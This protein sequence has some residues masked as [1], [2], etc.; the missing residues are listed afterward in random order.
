HLRADLGK[1]A[2]RGGAVTMAANGLKFAV[3]LVGT[4]VMARLLTPVDYGVIGMVAILTG[5]LSIF[6]DMGLAAATS[7]KP[8]VTID[9]VSS[10]L[11][12]NIGVCTALAVVTAAF[13][14]GL[15]WFYGDGRLTAITAVTAT[16]FIFNGLTVQHDAL[17]RRQMRFVAISSIS[18]T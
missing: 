16:G 10:L 11:W 7:Q 14:P 12:V 15:A 3:T 5:F 18:V 1:R 4:S 13:A 8:Q 2:A 9:Q 6:K 17:L